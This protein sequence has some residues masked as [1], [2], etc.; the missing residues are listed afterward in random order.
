MSV[1]AKDEHKESI[2]DYIFPYK[3]KNA[4]PE[5]V[6]FAIQLAIPGKAFFS[7]IALAF[8]TLHALDMPST[9]QHVQKKA[10]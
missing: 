4:L 10:V 5:K 3:T 6:I 8:T 9:V 1:L 2:I 7:Q